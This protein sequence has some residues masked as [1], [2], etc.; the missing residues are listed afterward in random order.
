MTDK[1]RELISSVRDCI[2]AAPEIPRNCATCEYMADD[3]LCTEYNSRPPLEYVTQEN[4]CYKW[5]MFIPF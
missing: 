3:G 1:H 4:D 5:I 2:S